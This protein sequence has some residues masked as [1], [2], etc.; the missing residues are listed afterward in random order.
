MKIRLVITKPEAKR[1]EHDVSLPLIIGRGHDAKYRIPHDRVSRRH[2]ELFAEDDVVYIRDLGS[3][4]GTLL[5]G[6]P[7]A[8]S[9]KQLVRPGME[10]G[11]GPLTIRIEYEGPGGLLDSAD[12]EAETSAAGMVEPLADEAE[13]VVIEESN[14]AFAAIE[15]EP[16]EPPAARRDHEPS[17]ATV[18]IAAEEPEIEMNE[19]PAG[20]VAESASPPEAEPPAIGPPEEEPQGTG[21]F[22]FL[23]GDD[24]GDE[25]ASPDEFRWSPGDEER[26]SSSD[27]EEL[28]DFLKGLP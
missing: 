26:Q 22:A 7:V 5:G 8:A 15:P 17:E 19:P 25:P 9:V 24:K 20:Q 6:K 4:N 13:A 3:T 27:D 18:D 12:I 21:D 23:E 1:Q 14:E 2:C 16:K 10:L 11:V 28:G